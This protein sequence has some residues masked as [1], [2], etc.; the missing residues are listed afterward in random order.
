MGLVESRQP[1][2]SAPPMTNGLQSVNCDDE[3]WLEGTKVLMKPPPARCCLGQVGSGGSSFPT[4]ARWPVGFPASPVV[5]MEKE[6]D[7]FNTAVRMSPQRHVMTSW[8][9]SSK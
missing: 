3:L 2:P 8:T 1:C 6:L 7:G 9:G 4:H 5:A